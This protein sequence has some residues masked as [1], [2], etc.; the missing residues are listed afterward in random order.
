MNFWYHVEGAIEGRRRLIRER[1]GA[2]L[3]VAPDVEA[4][5]IVVL[6]NP[7]LR[8][9]SGLKETTYEEQKK[10]TTVVP[11]LLALPEKVEDE[12]NLWDEELNELPFKKVYSKSKSDKSG[13][14]IE[15]AKDS[16]ALDACSICLEQ[17]F[18]RDSILVFEC[19]PVHYFHVP[20]AKGWLEK[21]PTCPLCRKQFDLTL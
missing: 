1:N 19:N 5:Q 12:A 18:G 6:E 9:I 13:S 17:F 14:H 3:I 15:I 11:D 20:C 16:D 4:V 8:Y 10:L 2:P 21:N 7:L